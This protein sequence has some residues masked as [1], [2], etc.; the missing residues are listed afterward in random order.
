MCARDWPDPSLTIQSGWGSS[1]LAPV[2][3]LNVET[4][5]EL[6]L[7]NRRL[8]AGRQFWQSLSDKAHPVMTLISDFTGHM[9]EY[10]VI[11]ES[12]IVARLNRRF[13]FKRIRVGYQKIRL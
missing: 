1:I 12:E 9:E 6:P 5:Y 7:V 13:N 10:G 4:Q 11:Q 8:R 3:D 2:D